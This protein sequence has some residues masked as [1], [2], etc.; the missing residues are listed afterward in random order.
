[1]SSLPYADPAAGPRRRGGFTLVELLV[2]LTLTG[3]VATGV[4]RVAVT[5]ARFV[6]L[7]AAREE[8]QQNLR[9]ALELISGDLRGLLPDGILSMHPDSI[10]FY[11]PR[12]WGVSCTPVGPTSDTLWA[13]IPAGVLGNQ[14][15]HGRPHWGVALGRGGEGAETST[16]WTFVTAPGRAAAA[17]PC[18]GTASAAD[19]PRTAVLGFVRPAGASFAD[20]VAPAGAAVLIFEEMKYDVTPSPSGAVPGRW[21]R[22]MVGRTAAGPNMQPLAGPVVARHGLRFRY[23]AADGAPAASAGEVRRVEIRV[24]VESRARRYGGPGVKPLHVDSGT[25]Q[26]VPRNAS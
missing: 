9:G 25:V 3:M 26:V 12:A 14:D 18:A 22:R 7:Q 23:F 13:I 21:L 17:S 16:R 6:D 10:R 11:L 2:A 1:M 20:S 24:V 4:Y 19:P 5:T 15:I 8:V